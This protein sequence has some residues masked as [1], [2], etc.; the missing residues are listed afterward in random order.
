MLALLMHNL[1]TLGPFPVVPE[2][3]IHHQWLG[4][5]NALVT[6]DIHDRLTVAFASPRHQVIIVS[7]SSSV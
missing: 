7:S 2:T 1:A 5:S 6:L 3:I 4:V